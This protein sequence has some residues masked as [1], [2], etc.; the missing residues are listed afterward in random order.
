MRR[1]DKNSPWEN[2]RVAHPCKN[3]WESME[4]GQYARICGECSFHVVLGADLEA[5]RLLSLFELLSRTLDHLYL[6]GSI[7]AGDPGLEL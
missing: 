4:G 2:I 5:K 1:H 6:L 7:R 3:T